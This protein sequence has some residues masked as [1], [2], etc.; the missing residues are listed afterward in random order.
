MYAKSFFKAWFSDWLALMSGAPTVPLAILALYVSSKP[1]RILYGSLAVACAILTSYRIWLKERLALELERKKNQ[2]PQIDAKFI[3]LQVV[4]R[5]ET[6]PLRAATDNQTFASDYD[7]F[8]EVFLVNQSEVVCTVQRY[9]AKA[10]LNGL[11]LKISQERDLG[12]H[13]L[14]F[15]IPNGRKRREE[16]NYLATALEGVALQRGIGVR[17]WLRF[18][19]AGVRNTDI[20][21][22]QFGLTIVDSFSG[23]HIV[24]KKELDASGRVEQRPGPVVRTL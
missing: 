24:S 5:L 9:E 20:D 1:Y 22:V 4:P 8:V 14:V 2:F 13:D 23:R 17:G 6:V 3:H 10:E 7:I 12:R 16:M 11:G 19:L 15:D 18:E 21:Q